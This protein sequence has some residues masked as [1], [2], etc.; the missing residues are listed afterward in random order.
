MYLQVCVRGPP[1]SNFDMSCRGGRK[2]IP[3]L[4][5]SAKRPVIAQ[6]LAWRAAVQTSLC[7]PELAL[8]LRSLDSAILWDALKRPTEEGPWTGAEILGRRPG[9]R[10]GWHYLIRGGPKDLAQVRMLYPGLR[11]PSHALSMAWH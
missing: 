7:S 6:R 3:G 9:T 4:V 1:A 11:P 5:Y 8:Q 10:A 2:R